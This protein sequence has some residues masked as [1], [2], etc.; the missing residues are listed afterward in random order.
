MK[1]E[2]A[3]GLGERS[4][5]I[6]DSLPDP[7]FFFD[8]AGELRYANAAGE[9]LLGSSG[10]TSRGFCDIVDCGERTFAQISEDVKRGISTGR[11]RSR[12]ELEDGKGRLIFQLTPVE[13]G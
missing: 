4:G 11:L 1:M 2:F 7:I 10:S 8:E 13:G 3:S 6:L 5:R 9:A 12:P